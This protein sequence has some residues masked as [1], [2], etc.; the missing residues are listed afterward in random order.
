MPENSARVVRQ[1]RTV[2]G[3]LSQG[4][5]RKALGYF[6]D[7]FGLATPDEKITNDHIPGL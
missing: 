6:L 1:S 7:V 4:D 3:M 5:L 2:L